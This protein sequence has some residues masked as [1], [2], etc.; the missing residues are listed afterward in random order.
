LLC[1]ADAE[2]AA[3]DDG[4]A[5]HLSRSDGT[6]EQQMTGTRREMP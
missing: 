5:R 6:D 1:I 3:S 2:V 4:N